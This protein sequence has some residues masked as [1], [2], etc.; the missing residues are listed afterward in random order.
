MAGHV[1]EG[2]R[3]DVEDRLAPGEIQTRL[4]FRVHPHVDV[5]QRVRRDLRTQGGQRLDQR[6]IRATDR[7]KAE[8]VI[9]QIGDRRVEPI[10]RMAKP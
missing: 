6:S 8:D 7:P 1:R 2:I 3:S 10:D 9:A 5:E 4:G